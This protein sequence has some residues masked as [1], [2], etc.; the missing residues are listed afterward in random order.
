MLFHIYAKRE[1]VE[2]PIFMQDKVPCH[3]AKTV[4]SFLKEKGIA[5]MKWPLQSPYI[6][7][8]ENVWKII[9]EKAQ[10]R[11]PQNIGDLWGFLKKYHYHLL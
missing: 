11:N 4:L 8:R 5:V 2:T 9:G 7:P 10:N 6:N 1:R 3:K